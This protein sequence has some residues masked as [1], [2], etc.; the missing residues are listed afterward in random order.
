MI[1]SPAET[2]GNPQI[3]ARD[4]YVP[5]EHDQL[6][7]ITFPGAPFLMNKSPWAVN[8]TA[9]ALGEHNAE[10]LGALGYDAQHLA[11]LTASEVI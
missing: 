8:S 5:I 4:Y 6:G 7:E 9:P 3:Q 11:Y 10:V 2:I 1:D